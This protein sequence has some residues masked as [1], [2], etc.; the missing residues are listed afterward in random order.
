MP[1]QCYTTIHSMLVRVRTLSTHCAIEDD[2]AGRQ[3]HDGWLAHIGASAHWPTSIPTTMSSRI[4]EHVAKVFEHS[5]NVDVRF[6][7]NNHNNDKRAFSQ[8]PTKPQQSRR[9]EAVL[10]VSI[11]ESHRDCGLN[12]RNHGICGTR[13]LKII[14][15]NANNY[16]S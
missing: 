7:W 8:Q 10:G 11:I 9:S 4:C 1:N 12:I 15:Q 6:E 3:T 13:L 2:G 5:V 14:F 16:E